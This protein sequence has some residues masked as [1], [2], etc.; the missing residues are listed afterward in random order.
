MDINKGNLGDLNTTYSAAFKGGL[1]TAPTSLS[2]QFSMEV[3][4]SG[5]SNKYPFLGALKGFREW[6]GPRVFNQLAS[7]NYTVDN[8]LW[9]DGF[10]MNRTEIEDDQF[11]LYIPI[12]SGLGQE[13]KKQRDQVMFDLLIAA[14]DEVC[15][16]GLPFFDTA[17]PVGGG[18]Q[19]ND[20][21]GTGA[22]WYLM[23]TSHTVKP[24]VFQN[25][26]APE[27]VA[28]TSPND[29][30]VFLE[31]I[32]RWGAR[33]R[34]NAGFGLWQLAVR[35]NQPLNEAN[36]LAAKAA[37][38]SFK[39][40]EGKPMGNRPTAIIVG[41][42]N[43]DVALKLFSQTLV[44]GGDTNYLKFQGINIVEADRFLP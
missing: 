16:D 21:G 14:G 31:D 38:R 5:P 11:G 35:S 23:D 19:S 7:H 12:A 13:A 9:E 34:N 32:F 3:P 2:Q 25:R 26:L 22:A 36:Y 24:M 17:H 20:L 39:N 6:V 30:G 43:V 37:L 44:G 40:D 41:G 4:S 18:V 10:E 1:D 28:K 8:K 27:F 42:S 15:Y 29:E 33:I